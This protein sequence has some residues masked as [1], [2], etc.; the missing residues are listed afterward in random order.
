MMRLFSGTFM[1]F[2]SLFTPSDSQNELFFFSVFLFSDWPKT[3]RDPFQGWR[4]FGGSGGI[5]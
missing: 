5:L 1:S 2:L 3:I 4:G